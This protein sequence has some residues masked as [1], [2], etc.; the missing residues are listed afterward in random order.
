[1]YSD[2]S[3]LNSLGDAF[4]MCCYRKL[5]IETVLCARI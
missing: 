2:D 4:G 3:N 1:M 5:I